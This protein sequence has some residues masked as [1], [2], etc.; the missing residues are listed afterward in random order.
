MLHCVTPEPDC[1][2]KTGFPLQV[3][4]VIGG[5]YGVFPLFMTCA[6]GV[7]VPTLESTC[8]LVYFTTK[9]PV[10]AITTIIPNPRN[11]IIQN[12]VLLPILLQPLHAKV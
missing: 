2:F 4:H 1:G 10:S 11:P 6:G 3:G 5:T 8:T 7:S 12:F 9:I